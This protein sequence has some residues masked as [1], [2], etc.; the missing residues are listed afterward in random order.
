MATAH[1]PYEDYVLGNLPPVC[2]VS[3]MPTRD[4]FVYRVDVTAIP[5]RGHGR[6]AG[7][8]DVALAVIDA[9][10][11][12]RIL[13]G[14]IPLDRDVQRSLVR[15]RRWWTVT[16]AAAVVGVIAAAWLAASWSP[17]ATAIA[18]SAA[19]VAAWQ[20]RNA[21]RALPRP[22]LTH[23]DARVVLDGVHDGFA[24]ALDQR[25]AR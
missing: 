22:S 9:R 4:V 20:R 1:V 21:R 7:S 6:L 23:D 25:E 16:L 10:T 5:A 11:P 3:G 14:R 17:A 24:A 8:L 18:A 13:V 2:I 12:R 19:G 15:R